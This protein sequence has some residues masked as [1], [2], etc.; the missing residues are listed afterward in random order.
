MTQ[1]TQDLDPDDIR[2]FETLPEIAHVMQDDY[3]TGDGYLNLRRNLV[4][5]SASPTTR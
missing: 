1:W 5:P 3:S 4:E 2:E